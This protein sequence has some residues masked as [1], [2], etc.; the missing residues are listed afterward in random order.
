M[1]DILSATLRAH[2]LRSCVQNRILRFCEPPNGGSITDH[3][4]H[5][6]IGHRTVQ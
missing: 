4:G 6:E 5:K 2:S 3:S 1:V